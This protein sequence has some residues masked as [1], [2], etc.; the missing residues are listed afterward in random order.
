[1]NRIILPFR[2]NRYA[3]NYG[4]IIM[5]NNLRTIYDQSMGGRPRKKTNAEKTG[6]MSLRPLFLILFILSVL[7]GLAVCVWLELTYDIRDIYYAWLILI[8]YSITGATLI[9]LR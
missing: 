9:F 5:K 7:S 2:A 4:Y 6:K 3:M 1:M 8:V